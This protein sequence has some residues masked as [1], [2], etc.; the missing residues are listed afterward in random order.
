M[1]ALDLDSAVADGT[2]IVA[3]DFATGRDCTARTTFE[4]STHEPTTWPCREVRV[5]ERFRDIEVPYDDDEQ[6]PS[7]PKPLAERLGAVYDWCWT[8]SLGVYLRCKL[9][10]PAGRRRVEPSQRELRLTHRW[11]AGHRD[12]NRGRH[13]DTRLNTSRSY[14]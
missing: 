2:V 6:L 5:L 9:Y 14:R 4:T 13:R 3:V 7:D 11:F 10:W 12:R 8:P 1:I